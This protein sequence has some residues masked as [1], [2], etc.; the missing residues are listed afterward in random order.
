[1][2][3]RNYTYSLSVNID[4]AVVYSIKDNDSIIKLP[5]KII[6]DVLLVKYLS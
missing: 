5:E 1:M 2:R 6:K 3:L 4:I